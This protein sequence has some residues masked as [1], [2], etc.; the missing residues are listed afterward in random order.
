MRV[1]YD[2]KCQSYFLE[3]YISKHA[4]LLGYETNSEQRRAPGWMDLLVGCHRSRDC[5][6]AQTLLKLKIHVYMLQV[7]KHP[8]HF[9][10]QVSLG[11]L[12]SQL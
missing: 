10:Q 8:I 1:G 11:N 5:P 6:M 2:C 4:F 3:I 7:I 9:Q 12:T